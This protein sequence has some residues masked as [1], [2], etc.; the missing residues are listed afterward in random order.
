VAAQ[1]LNSFPDGAWLVEL[2]PLASP[3]LV[4]QAVATVLGLREGQE[5]PLL[6]LLIDYLRDKHLL[7]LL[8]NCEH[9]VGSCAQLIESLLQT[10]PHLR[11]LTT[12]REALSIAGEMIFAVPSLSLPDPHPP[13]V[14]ALRQCES[15]CLFLERARSGL[16]DFQL[17]VDNASA[18][19]QV[20]RR[21]DGIP[22]ALEL[23]AAKVNMLRVEQI[24]ARLSDRFHLLTGGS[25]TALPRQQTL[26]A[27][28]DWS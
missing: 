21:L 5:T 27:T 12:S 18:V 25:R 17:T 4:P 6:T 23:A 11:I 20:C 26:L 15:V 24:A 9:V 7:L 14:D 10:C 28:M 19:A 13:T 8:D 3:N 1:I 16:P 2:A 22:L